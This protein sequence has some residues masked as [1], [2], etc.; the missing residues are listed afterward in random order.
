MTSR[1]LIGY[2]VSVMSKWTH[3]FAGSIAFWER[4]LKQLCKFSLY[5]VSDTTWIFI[6]IFSL[7][8]G[9]DMKIWAFDSRLTSHCQKMRRGL[10]GDAK[11]V[12]GDAKEVEKG[13]ANLLRTLS[14]SPFAFHF[15]STFASPMHP[16]SNP[17]CIQ[18]KMFYSDAKGWLRMKKGRGY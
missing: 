9:F 1:L 2:F 5:Q 17:L 7:V 15:T 18:E 10:K 4:K 12:K 14:E 11:V 8:I 3:F 16:P 13:D 6:H